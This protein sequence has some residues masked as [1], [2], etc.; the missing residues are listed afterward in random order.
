MVAYYEAIE[1]HRWGAATSLLSPSLRTT[2]KRAPDSDEHNTLSVSR[3]DVRGSDVAAPSALPI[4]KRSGYHDLWVITVMYDA[5]YKKEI[6][7]PD[8][9]QYR[10]IYLGRQNGTGRWTILDIGTGP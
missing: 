4:R 8:G 10:F 3:V 9:A 6:T 7:E 2:L 5:V 1:S